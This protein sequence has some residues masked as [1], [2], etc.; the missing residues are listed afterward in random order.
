[1]NKRTMIIAIIVLIID[2]ITK[3]IA[4]NLLSLG[5]SIKVIKNF[6]YFSLCHNDGVAWSLLSDHRIIIIIISL[7]GLIVIYRFMYCFKSNTRNN[8]AFGLVLGGLTGN[9]L[10]RLISGSVTDFLDFYIFKYD[11]P[12]FNAGDIA[13]VVGVLLLVYAIIKGEDVNE[14]NSKPKPSKN[15]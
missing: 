5:E 4:N 3:I 6:F 15:R 1:M 11:F 14:D 7:I 8:I 13:I 9:L 2:Q 12:V 10:D